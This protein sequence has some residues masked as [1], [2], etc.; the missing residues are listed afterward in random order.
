MKFAK[1]T[2]LVTATHTPFK[3]DGELN[4]DIVEKQAEQLLRNGIRTVFVGG[5]TGE[6]HSLSLNEHLLLGRRWLEVTRGAKLEVIVHVGSNCLASSRVLAAQA[7]Q[8]KARAISALSP[9]YFKPAN[10]ALLAECCAQIAAGAPETPFYFYDIPVL[11][12]VNLP[13]PEFLE[14]A[15]PLIPNLAGIKYTN[16]DQ[17]MLLECLRFADGA[18]DILWGIDE[19]LVGALAFGVQ[20]AVG[21]TYNFAAP[22]AR[23]LMQNFANGKLARA[24]EEQFRLIQTIRVLCRRGYLPSAKA[25]MEMLGVDVGPTRLPMAALPK[26]EKTKLRAELEA[27]GFFD[28]IR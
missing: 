13:M 14:R 11:T 28:W 25:L 9:S 3:P 22:I 15:R 20:G 10:A 5:S 12:G 6:S 24:R 21:S 17:A 1:L 26:K 18:F 8:F 16:S 7:G 4:L 23:R 19:Y 2:G 27:L